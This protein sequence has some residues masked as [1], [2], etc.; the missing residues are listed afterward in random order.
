MSDIYSLHKKV[1]LHL[2]EAV[3]GGF[4]HNTSEDQ[5]QAAASKAG[6]RVDTSS[7]SGSNPVKKLLCFLDIAHNFPVYTHKR[8]S[9]VA[10][11]DTL[12]HTVAMVVLSSERQSATGRHVKQRRRVSTL[13]LLYF[14]PNANLLQGV[15]L[16]SVVGFRHSHCSMKTRYAAWNRSTVDLD[17]RFDS[18]QY[19]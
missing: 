2:P 1:V 16:S 11:R 18:L 5:V 7:V 14:L 4:D 10:L 9:C 6:M 17:R 3:Q 19:R 12:A 13:S 8:Q 15:M